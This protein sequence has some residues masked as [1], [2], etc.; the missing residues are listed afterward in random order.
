[1]TQKKSPLSKQNIAFFDFDE[2]LI[3]N[4]SLLLFQYALLGKTKTYLSFF[5][6]LFLT[7]IHHLKGSSKGEDFK[8]SVKAEWIYLT[9]RHQPIKHL[10]KLA[11][12]IASQLTWKTSIVQKLQSHA[13]NGDKIIIATG[14]LSIFIKQI[15][16]QKVPYDA[17]LSTEMEVKD[18]KLTGFIKGYNCVRIRKAE[19]IQNYLKTHGPFNTIYAYGNLPS[20]RYM[21]DLAD[22]AEAIPTKYK[23]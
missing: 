23:I 9:M 8:G 20:D 22:V 10:E 1:M 18:A 5:Q 19:A 6:A 14:A 11:E 12:S 4:D 3:E 17:I 7:I 16:N 13:A 21:L 2:T 15:I